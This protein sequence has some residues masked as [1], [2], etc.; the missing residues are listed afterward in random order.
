M[1][2]YLLELFWRDDSS[3]WSNI[4]I[5]SKLLIK[6]YNQF[7]YSFKICILSKPASI[8]LQFMQNQFV[9]N[10]NDVAL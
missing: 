3:K 8:E 4:R 1:F 5:R 9:Q 10:M 6:L 2:D 7:L